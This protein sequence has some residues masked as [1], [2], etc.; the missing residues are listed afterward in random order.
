MLNYQLIA[1]CWL[2]IG[3]LVF[4]LLLFIKA[5]YGRHTRT[6]WGPMIDNRLGW[7]LM[8]LVV[9]GILLYFVWHGENA[10]SLP[11]AVILALFAAHYIHRSL[12]FPFALHTKGKKMPL[13]IM[14]MAVGFNTMNGYLLGWYF[15]NLANYPSNWLWDPHFLLGLA[16][17]LMGMGINIW[18]DYHLIALRK[19]GETGYKIPEGGLFRYI[20]CPNHFGEILEWTGFAVLN[21]SLPGLI[22]AI[23]TFANLA[24]RALAH[25][26]WYREKFVDYPKERKALIPGVW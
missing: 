18:S 5:P 12:I 14:L 20:S 9:L 15:G 25:H 4:V 11:I 23:W 22:F 7:V 19:P 13:L 17:F 8:E 24:P 1:Y 26:R 16:L 6:G 10:I 21:W 3:L 2:C